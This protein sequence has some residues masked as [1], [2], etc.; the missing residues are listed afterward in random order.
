MELF[1]LSKQIGDDKFVGGVVYLVYGSDQQVKV[2]L[3]RRNID[4]ETVIHPSYE[5]A[6]RVFSTETEDILS[7]ELKATIIFPKSYYLLYDDPRSA[8]KGKWSIPNYSTLHI[9]NSKVFFII[10]DPYEDTK[11]LEEFYANL[12]GGSFY[13]LKLPEDRFPL[14]NIRQQKSGLEAIDS[15]TRL[16]EDLV[17]RRTESWRAINRNNFY[18][19]FGSKDKCPVINSLYWHPSHKC[20]DLI[21]WLSPFVTQ[22]RNE[23]RQHPGDRLGMFALWVKRASTVWSEPYRKGLVWLNFRGKDILL[24][25][26]SQKAI[27][28]YPL[29][30]H[31][32]NKNKNKITKN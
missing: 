10:G 25:N 14:T 27:E 7:K 16:I 12:K 20:R 22:L 9:S 4:Y 19:L 30:L 18:R 1:S 32:K 21:P 2:E 31:Q 6:E 17:S 26:P 13:E 29:Y 28:Q 24:F 11:E 5:E 23:R 3:L 15:Y 8:K